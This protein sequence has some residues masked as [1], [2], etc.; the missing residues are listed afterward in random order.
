MSD[1]FVIQTANGLVLDIAGGVQGGKLIIYQKH[2]GNNQLWRFEEGRLVNKIGMVADIM[3]GSTEE[4]AEVIAW[5]KHDGD[6]QKWSMKENF[7]H[8]ELTD[9]V[10]D[11][12]EGHMEEGAEVIMFPKHGGSNQM[13]FVY[14]L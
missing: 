10:M 6:N 13:W 5:E 8:S 2:R 3:A 4:E 12:K 7:I 11:L 14:P 9:M 1:W